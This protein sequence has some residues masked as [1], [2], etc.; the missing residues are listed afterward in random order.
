MTYSY[1]IVSLYCFYPIQKKDIFNVREQLIKYEFKE[2]SGL[3]I[4]AEEGINGTFC[5]KEI[6]VDQFYKEIK[7][8][9]REQDLNEKI[10]YSRKRIFKK[11]KIKIKPEIVTMG[12]P[13]IHPREN[14]GIYMDPDEWNSLLND[15]ETV[16]IDTRNHYEVSLGSF[17]NSINPNLN[18]FREF[19]DWFDKN[20]ENFV[21]KKEKTKIAMF[22][23]GGIRCEKAT[24]LLRNKGYKNVYHL[25]GGILNYL[26]NVSPNRSLYKGECYV[27]DERVSLDKNL[28]NGSYS[29]CH[30][31]GMPLSDDDKNNILYVEGIQCHLCI[32]KFSDADRARF[33]ERQKQIEE[34]DKKL[35]LSKNKN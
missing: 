11:L 30:A 9:F 22:C 19:P 14:S 10:S 21:K 33:A 3:I 15:E 17:K 18:N 16:V 27:F 25:K 12:T 24:S 28:Q 13:N 26:E 7:N 35:N 5:G 23:T 4:L 8:L 20:I 29:I 1:K 31:C 6:I 2:L 34:K 32:D